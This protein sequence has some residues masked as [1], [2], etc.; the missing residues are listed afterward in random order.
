MRRF[1]TPATPIRYSGS[2]AK[3]LVPSLAAR[4]PY[5]SSPKPPTPSESSVNAAATKLRAALDERMSEIGPKVVARVQS[6]LGRW[7]EVSG[8]EEVE[9]LKQG[10]TEVGEST[11]LIT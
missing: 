8:Y 10:V 4:R 5:S 11:L 3:L 9:K 2:Q 7:N 6:A 1:L